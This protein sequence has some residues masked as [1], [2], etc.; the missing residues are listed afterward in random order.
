MSTNPYFN[1]TSFPPFSS[2]S[3]VGAQ[4]RAEG[5]R[6]VLVS[7][8]VALRTDCLLTPL[9]KKCRQTPILYIPLFPHFLHSP[10]SASRTVLKARGW[11]RTARV[12]VSGVCDCF[13]PS[14]KSVGKPLF[15][16]YHFPPTNFT[17]QQALSGRAGVARLASD[18]SGA[19]L[20]VSWLFWASAKS[21]DKP[22]F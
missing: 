18:G 7:S 10:H 14:A 4:S 12:S 11:I 9:C 17:P 19:S 15:Y 16:T 20:G 22:L 21:V 6:L 1:S 3:T 5:M 8:G 13:G 2:L